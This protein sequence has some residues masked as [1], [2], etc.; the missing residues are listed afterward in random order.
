M[1][2]RVVIPARY[3]STRLPG[4]PLAKLAG[5]PMIQHVHARAVASGAEEVVIATDDFQVRQ[6]CESFG[7]RVCMTST[8]H[9]TGTDRLAEAVAVLGWPDGTIVVNLQ[10][11]EPL[12]P[13]SAVRQ[14]AELLEADSDAQL[15][16][17][18][19]PIGTLEEYLNPNVVKVVASATGEA[20]YFSRAPIPWSRDTVRDGSPTDFSG[21]RRHIG[22]YAYRVAALRQLAHTPPCAIEEIEKLEQLR[23]LWHGLRIRV[24]QAH[25]VPGRGVDTPEDLHEVERLLTANWRR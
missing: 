16:T 11:D 1:A 22:L 7:A 9:V 24:A 18:C 3:A 4:K 13:P 19:T 2:F 20:L 6:V 23:A 17:L 8:R 21:A 15:A 14:V 5:K 12:M 10:G 25:E